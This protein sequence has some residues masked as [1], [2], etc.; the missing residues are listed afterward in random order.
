MK[1]VDIN[2]LERCIQL[3]EKIGEL[4][5]TT[6]DRCSSDERLNG[7]KI[8]DILRDFHNTIVYER[9]ML[10]AKTSAIKDIS[11]E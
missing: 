10:T 1:Q 5:L 2:R 9:E 11:N 3:Y 7:R 8:G 4:L 6:I